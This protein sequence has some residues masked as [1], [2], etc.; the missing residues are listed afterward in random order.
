MVLRR[1]PLSMTSAI[2]KAGMVPG[3]L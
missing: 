1:R 3:T 2:S